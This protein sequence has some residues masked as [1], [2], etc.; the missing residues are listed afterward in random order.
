M[1]KSISKGIEVICAGFPKTGTKSLYEASVGN[2]KP[3]AAARSYGIN[4]AT[5]FPT[6]NEALKILGYN[7]YEV[8]DICCTM[9]DEWV[10]ILG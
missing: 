5:S 1:E 4:F 3:Y 2:V 7:H 8:P 10:Q 9:L 6:L